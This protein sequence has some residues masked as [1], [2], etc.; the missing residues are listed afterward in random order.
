MSANNGQAGNDSRQHLLNLL[1]ASPSVNQDQ[2]LPILAKCFI[3]S[4][5][6]HEKLHKRLFGDGSLQ[7]KG[8]VD[9]IK[10]SNAKIDKDIASIN[11][12]LDPVVS[13]H[14]NVVKA[15]AI[16]GAPLMLF[17]GWA[18]AWIRDHFKLH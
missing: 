2:W 9:E 14:K 10:D 11:D 3:E 15:A 7:Q 1:T 12:R 18:G 8:L 16:L 4:E 5:E 17:L 13:F 6:R